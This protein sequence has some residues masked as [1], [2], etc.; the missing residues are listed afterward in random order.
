MTLTF[1]RD[2]PKERLQISSATIQPSEGVKLSLPESTQPVE[3]SR[4]SL[5]NDFTLSL[6]KQNAY[7][8][9]VK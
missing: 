3:L 1:W 9:I 7:S 4:A 2:K 5:L 6:N 8:T